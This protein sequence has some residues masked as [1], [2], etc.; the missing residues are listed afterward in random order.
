MNEEIDQYGKCLDKH[1]REWTL[2]EE[3]N[4][5]QLG[6][7]RMA[8][9][10]VAYIENQ[11]YNPVMDM[12]GVHTYDILKNPI[13]QKDFQYFSADIE[14]RDQ[15]I[16]SDLPENVSDVFQSDYVRIV[17]SLAYLPEETRKKYFSEEAT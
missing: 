16:I 14:D 3:E 10:S 15:F 8:E 5:E 11:T 1:N 7:K 17:L 12:M 13:Y 9:D 2:K 4:N 6:I